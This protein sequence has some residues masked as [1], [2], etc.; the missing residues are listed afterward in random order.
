MGWILALMNREIRGLHEA[1]YLLAL[2]AFLS[3][4]LAL[5]RDRTFAHLFG[6][7]PT[8]DAYFAA[9][10]VPDLLFAFLTLFVSSFA[11]I[12]LLAAR[13]GSTSKESQSLIGSVLLAFGVVSILSAAAL[14]FVLPHVVPYVFPGFDTATHH[15]VVTLSQIMLL[16]PI[17]LGLSS[18]IG[19]LVQ[20]ARKFMLYALAPIMYNLGI[21]FGALILYPTL[22]TVGL[23]W[24]VVLG[25]VL[26][27]L[28]QV[29]P[30][31]L[32]RA[33]LT[34][35]LS[36]QFLADTALVVKRSLPRALALSSNQLLMLVLVSIAS[37]AAA[38]SVAAIS[39][40]FNLQSVPLSI[41]GVSY[42]AA[43][44]PSLALLFSKGEHETFVSEVWAAT[45]H[46]IFWTA[47]AI[48][49]MIVLRAHVV[50][51][52]LGSGQFSW[53]DTRL[54]AAILAGFVISLIAQAVMLI[55]SRAYYAAGRD[56][57]PVV[58]NVGTALV[59]GMVAFA[60]F[61][62][63]EDTTTW[64]YF[65]ENLFRIENIP[66]SG[67][68]MIAL[69]YSAVMTLGALLFATLFAR[70]FGFEGRVVRTLGYSIAASTIGA[71]AAYST[72]QIFGP[73]LPTDTFVGILT[74]G[75]SA[76]VVGLA[77]WALV[78]LLLRSREFA[79]VVTV[80]LRLVRK[81][82]S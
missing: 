77:V 50:R 58:V 19:A 79:E 61:T 4:V 17:L 10:K 21:I 18:I 13:G 76:G 67:A 81:P 66:G 14:F 11:I 27:F 65:I 59:A 74:Q 41:V 71:A 29:T 62:I 57:V 55:F 47:P 25:A 36:S 38:G 64:A 28:I 51:V 32:G 33:T 23:A 80:G 24:G 60:A 68:V 56:R 2:F 30:L 73:L 52:I 1:A 35:R 5:V 42:A 82:H 75:V 49:L 26:H 40:A 53:N 6:A 45:R 8:L 54:T 34:P 9:F 44:F 3:Q 12:P 22:G 39:F 16:Q 69:G 70:D 63:F 7:G 46:I 37:L 31:V 20:A 15:T 43:L 78:L 72:L 48:A